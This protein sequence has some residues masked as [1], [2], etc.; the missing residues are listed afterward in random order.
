MKTREDI[1]AAAKELFLAQGYS[2]VTVADIARSADVALKTV[3]VSVGSKSE[4]LHT[5]L[6]A[7]VDESAAPRTLEKINDAPDLEGAVRAIAH[8]TRCNTERFADSIEL[9]LASRAAD[10]GAAAT[11]DHILGE[12]RGALRAAAERL[13]HVRHLPPGTDIDNV[14]DQL[15][16]YFGLGSWRALT[17]ECRWTFDRAETWLATRALAALLLGTP[18]APA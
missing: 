6:T 18:G 17:T 1:L 9:L 2:R 11:W 4:I 7:D 16:F 10:S 15:W 3:Y 14:S 13:V 5:L 8:G 12:Y